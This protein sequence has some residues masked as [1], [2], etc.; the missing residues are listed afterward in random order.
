MLRIKQGIDLKEL[1]KYGFEGN[2]KEY[3][4]DFYPYD[5]GSG[6]YILIKNDTRRIFFDYFGLDYFD[7]ATEIL[8]DLIQDGLVEKV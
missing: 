6:E 2:G 5:E 8:Y 4:Y 3:Y 7:K 1:K